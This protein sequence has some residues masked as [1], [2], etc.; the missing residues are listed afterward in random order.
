MIIVTFD[1][2][3]IFCGIFLF[4]IRNMAKE[5]IVDMVVTNILISAH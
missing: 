1:S 3:F 2:N 4:L 5:F